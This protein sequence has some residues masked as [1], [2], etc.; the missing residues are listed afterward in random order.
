LQAKGGFAGFDKFT[1]K[2]TLYW[3]KLLF[4]IILS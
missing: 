4:I 2:F 3:G 1:V